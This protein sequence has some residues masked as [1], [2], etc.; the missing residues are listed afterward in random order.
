MSLIVVSE[1]Y[2]QYNTRI[3]ISDDTGTTLYAEK[4]WISENHSRDSLSGNW[5][6]L[7][8]ILKHPYFI[9]F[10]LFSYIYTFMCLVSQYDARHKKK[11]VNV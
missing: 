4:I 1:Y 8:N 3:G 2:K 11:I 10:G 7:V 6:Y 5:K 9:L